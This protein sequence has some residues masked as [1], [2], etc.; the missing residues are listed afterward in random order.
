MLDPVEL[1]L[2]DVNEGKRR[3]DSIDQGYKLSM[4]LNQTRS[5]VETVDRCDSNAP[6]T[7]L[8]FLQSFSAEMECTRDRWSCHLTTGPCPPR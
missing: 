6:R 4:G 1:V 7:Y 2:I 8:L 5:E 3:V